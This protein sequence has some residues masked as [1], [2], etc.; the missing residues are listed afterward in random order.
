MK[1]ASGM[2]FPSRAGKKEQETFR[3]VRVNHTWVP[4]HFLALSK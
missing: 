3:I 1:V 2:G 4:G